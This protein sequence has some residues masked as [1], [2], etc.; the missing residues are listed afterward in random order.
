MDNTQS[1]SQQ[2]TRF[3]VTLAGILIYAFLAL[4][5]LVIMLSAFSLNLTRSFLRRDFRCVGSARYYR[6]TAGSHRFGSARCC[7]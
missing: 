4:P 3:G 2:L 1:L 6:M 7:W 5:V